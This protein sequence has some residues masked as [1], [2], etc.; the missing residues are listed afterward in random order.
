MKR[1]GSVVPPIQYGKRATQLK[2][3]V[4]CHD[5]NGS[6]VIL[7]MGKWNSKGENRH[8]CMSPHYI[9]P[10]SSLS[11]NA[12]QHSTDLDR[13]IIALYISPHIPT[14]S[15]SRIIRFCRFHHKLSESR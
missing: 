5:S 1:P 3:L 12:T 4:G 6:T 7:L 9:K 11:V 15:T 2:L 14:Y 13:D 10:F 8:P